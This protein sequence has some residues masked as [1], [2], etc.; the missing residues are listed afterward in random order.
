MK[1][2]IQK[3]RFVKQIL[4]LIFLVAMI[5]MTWR[6]TRP[7]QIVGVYRGNYASD[8]IIKN[9]PLTSRQFVNWWVNQ[10]DF[11]FQTYGP[12]ENKYDLFKIAIWD[13]G[14][15][16]QKFDDWRPGLLFDFSSEQR[17][18]EEIKSSKNC[19]DKNARI[20]DVFKNS[21]NVVVFYIN[22]DTYY[23]F[24]DGE[25]IKKNEEQ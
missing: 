25:I 6:I 20:M 11:I 14:A 2:T 4:L 3:K 16:F 15:G 5:F 10:Q 8:I 21:D 24:E 22:R 23:L 19:L 7:V 9:S 1:T 18:F 12:F 17:C 13:I